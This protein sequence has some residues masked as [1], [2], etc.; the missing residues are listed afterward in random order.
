MR[1]RIRSMALQEGTGRRKKFKWRNAK[2][3]ATGKKHA[4][5][6]QAGFQTTPEKLRLSLIFL[7]E[8]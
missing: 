4:E 8:S 6:K 5:P 3:T 2:I 7:I 1:K